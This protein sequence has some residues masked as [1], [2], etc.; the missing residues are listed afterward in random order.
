[1][2]HI[3][4]TDYEIEGDHLFNDIIKELGQIEHDDKVRQKAERLTELEMVND[5]FKNNKTGLYKLDFD[6]RNNV[7]N[8]Y[9]QGVSM[10]KISKKYDLN[11]KTLLSWKKKGCF[12]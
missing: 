6:V 9:K 11:Y 2:A 1:M 10:T 12:I 3:L 8:D 5:E 7:L 4:D